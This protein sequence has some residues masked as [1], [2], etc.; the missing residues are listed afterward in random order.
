V[1]GCIGRS[2]GVHV[3]KLAGMP[4]SIVRR[5]EAVL[6]HLEN[7]RL[8][9]GK[10]DIFAHMGGELAVGAYAHNGDGVMVAETNGHYEWQSAE[11]EMVAIAL[12]QADGSEPDLDTI[13]LSA[14]TPLDALNLL[15]LLQKKRS[16]LRK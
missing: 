11:A 8:A 13:H 15:F 4:Q 5:A 16:K 1:P 2:Y 6:Q 14:I 10:Q 7:G 3:A 12:E 9:G